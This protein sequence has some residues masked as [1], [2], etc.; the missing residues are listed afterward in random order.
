MTPRPVACLLLTLS[1]AAC[2]AEAEFPEP[3]INPAPR[4]AW[5][6]ELEVE[7]PV[8]P[9][10]RVEMVAAYNIVNAECL[11]REL[12]TGAPKSPDSKEIPLAVESTSDGAFRA[13]VF[14]DLILPS[15]LYGEGECRWTL[16]GVYSTV[17]DGIV[18]Y[19]HTGS[20]TPLQ[21]SR[22]LQ[23][24]NYTAFERGRF[25]GPP[26]GGA[27]LTSVHMG[28]NREQPIGPIEPDTDFTSR[29]PLDRF[30]RMRSVGRPA[31]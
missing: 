21:P 5:A 14:V 28:L 30:V 20:V 10:K 1:L 3:P 29:F 2:A 15:D 23:V 19:R 31:N 27:V 8:R 7:S 11:E 18:E 25:D 16:A 22:V 12:F 4:D 17:D 13:R 26:V 24:L 6:F 9:V